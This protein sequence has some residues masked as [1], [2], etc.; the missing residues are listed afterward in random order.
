MLRSRQGVCPSGWR[1]GSSSDSQDLPRSVRPSVRPL[2]YSEGLLSISVPIATG[3]IL[4]V[5]LLSASSNTEPSRPQER[6]AHSVPGPRQGSDGIC[7]VKEAG[8]LLA[9]LHPSVSP[10][11]SKDRLCHE[12]EINI[13][14]YLPRECELGLS[15]S[16]FLFVGWFCLFFFL[17]LWNR[18]LGQP[19][20]ALGQCRPCHVT[21]E[22]G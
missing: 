14:V 13:E 18:F 7:S 16:S 12:C 15:L 6:C 22:I 1:T 8:I 21:L 5:L 9:C 2:E 17:I 11:R 3:A 10:R 4:F 20:P 19:A